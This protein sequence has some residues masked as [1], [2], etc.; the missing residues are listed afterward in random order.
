MGSISSMPFIVMRQAIVL[1]ENRSMIHSW[2]DRYAP[3][4]SGST[5]FFLAM[6]LRGCTAAGALRYSA[7]RKRKASRAVFSRFTGSE[8]YLDTQVRHYFQSGSQAAGIGVELLYMTL[9]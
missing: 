3:N 1:P 7:N 6:K 2:A 8:G 5:L 9:N 4:S